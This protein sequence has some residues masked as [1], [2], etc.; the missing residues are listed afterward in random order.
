M[1]LLVLLIIPFHLY[2]WDSAKVKTD[3]QE[4]KSSPQSFYQSYKPHKS[5]SKRKINIKTKIESRQSFS[6]PNQFLKSAP[7]SN[8]RVRKLFPYSQIESN[9]EELER[10]NLTQ[11]QLSFSPW[12]DDYW[13]IY[14]GVLGAR[15]ATEDFDLVFS[16]DEASE[17]VEKHP[18]DDSWTRE[19]MNTLSPAEKYDLLIGNQAYGALTKS[20]WAQGRTYFDRN[21][22]VENWMGI[23]H[24][25]AVASFMMDRPSNAITVKSF[26][27]KF[28][29]TFYPSDIKALASLLW[30]EVRFQSHFIGG[31]CSSKMPRLDDNGRPIAK[32]CLDNNPAT[33]HQSLITGI[34]QN[35][36]SFVMDATY[37]YEVWNQ[38]IVSYQYKYF[39]LIEKEEALS[40]ADALIAKKDYKDDQFAKH[41]HAK[42]KY[43]V[44][45]AM[46]V[47]YLV[48]TPPNHRLQDSAEF[49]AFNTAYYY[50]DLELDAQ[51]NIIGGEWQHNLHPDFLWRPI[52]DAQA[53]TSNDYFLLS[54]PLWNGDN[55]LPYD[56]AEM[57]RGPARSR[58][59]L[60]YIVK[61][62]I[63]LSNQSGLSPG[64]N[65]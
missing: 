3:L 31:R 64:S 32:D 1:K 57:A 40:L 51:K 8:D 39:N 27:G 34:G 20:M 52:D 45:I 65:K 23:C 37:D 44:G 2:A 62:L 58:E 17:Y 21:G 29:I 35:N 11:A 46:E 54:R 25:W 18:W 22:S 38:P 33:F 13:P 61:S 14:K 30:A 12:S 43:L 26:D 56:I 53:L 50:Y 59:P 63:L 36:Q 47:K 9:I 19:Q 5:S 28:D 4:L 24:G 42:T 6:A 16:W 48:E 7:R 49:D 60:A 15:Y 41:R 10:K 55:S